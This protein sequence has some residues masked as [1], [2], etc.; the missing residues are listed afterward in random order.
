MRRVQRPL[1][2]RWER[3]PDRKV[4]AGHNRAPYPLV[5]RCCAHVAPNVH[6]PLLTPLPLA[7]SRHKPPRA[8][9]ASAGGCWG[10]GR[11]GMVCATIP[12]PAGQL[13]PS[14]PR[15]STHFAVFKERAPWKSFLAR[16]T[17]AAR[18][19]PGANGCGSGV[20]WR[21]IIVCQEGRGLR[22]AVLEIKIR[23]F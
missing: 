5:V 23:T 2:W 16:A 13:C 6:F 18:F 12:A 7:W 21:C 14:P 11:R 8:G 1:R 17:A 15:R 4:P 9:L 20:V 10:R 3:I 19:V 22:G